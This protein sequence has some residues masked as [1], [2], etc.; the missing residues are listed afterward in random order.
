MRKVNKVTDEQIMSKW[1]SLRGSAKSRGLEFDLS[2]TSVRN[3]LAAKK[4][5]YTKEFFN[6]S[7]NSPKYKTIDRIDPNKGYVKGNVVACSKGFNELKST[8][9]HTDRKTLNKMIKN[10]QFIVSKMEK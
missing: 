10:L 9:E 4:C 3:L 5:F 7:K 2:L 8:F 6:S 1:N